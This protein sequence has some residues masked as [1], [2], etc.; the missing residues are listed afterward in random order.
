VPSDFRAVSTTMFDTAYMK[1][2]FDLGY[3]QA[4]RTYRWHK[5]PPGY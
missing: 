1:S 2:L 5:A 4:S 3:E